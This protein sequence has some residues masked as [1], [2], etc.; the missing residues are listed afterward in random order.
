MGVRLMK[1]PLFLAVMGGVV[2]ALSV[3]G[4]LVDDGVMASEW[5]SIV[6][7][8]LLGTGLTAVPNGRKPA[9]AV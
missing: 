7:A 8:G 6:L 1:S 3:A 2:A 5:I 4:P 9:V